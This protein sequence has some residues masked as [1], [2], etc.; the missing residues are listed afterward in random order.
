MIVLKGFGSSNKIL[1]KGYSHYVS[2][3]DKIINARSRISTGITARSRVSTGVVGR[4]V[5]TKG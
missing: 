5:I 3:G 1:T 2:T 4:S